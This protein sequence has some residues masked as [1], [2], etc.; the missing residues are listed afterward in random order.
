MNHRIAFSSS[1]EE[2][3]AHINNI[4]EPLAKQWGFSYN[5]FNQSIFSAKDASR[6]VKLEIQGNGR[7][8]PEGLE[9]AP[10]TPAKG[11]AFDLMAGT[12]KGVFGEETVVAPSGMHGGFTDGS[13]GC[14]R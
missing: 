4:I 13:P 8:G 9:P 10:I 5:A 3:K 11:D 7:D 12:I 6:R 14:S 2:T 1:V